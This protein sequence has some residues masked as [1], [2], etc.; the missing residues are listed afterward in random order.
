MG[1]LDGAKAIV[2][3]GASGIGEA[4]CRRFVAEGAAVAVLDRNEEAAAKLAADI[5]GVAVVADVASGEQVAAAVA[6][7]E[8][9]LGGLTTLVN[10]AGI[11]NVKPL[12]D[13]TDDDWDLLVN[14]NQKGVFN[15]MRAAAPR[16]IANG[17]GAI[18]NM[19]SVSGIRPT[20]GE[21]PYA[22]AKAG[23]IA[24]SQS[25]A[26]EYGPLVRVNT[27]SPG[28]IES[29]LTSFAVGDPEIKAELEAGTP[30]GRIGSSDEVAKAI[31][32]LC[33][34]LASYITGINLVVDGGSLLPSPQVDPLLKRLLP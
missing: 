3:G 13:Y 27:I 19:A 2:T 29:P 34:D 1:L 10:N 7:A 12:H 32:F 20:R 17:G 21:S 16:I 23:A 26:L 14:V 6:S 28:F 31:T 11:G 22:A 33:S 25:G 8:E 4:T 18:V 24:L 9:Q 5:G 15:G 30:L